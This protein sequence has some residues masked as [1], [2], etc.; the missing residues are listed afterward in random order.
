M[1]DVGQR[2]APPGAWGGYFLFVAVFIGIL[3]LVKI[4]RTGDVV[5]PT[6]G[7]VHDLAPVR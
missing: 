5:E 1:T 3:A 7:R 2:S 4:L 6:G